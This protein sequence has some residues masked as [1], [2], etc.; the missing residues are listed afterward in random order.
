LRDLGPAVVLGLSAIVLAVMIRPPV[1]LQLT[2]L[3]LAVAAAGTALAVEARLRDRLQHWLEPVR[4]NGAPENTGA[5]LQALARG[6]VWGTGLGRGR[7]D[8]VTNAENDFILSAVT[9][10]RG[11]VGAACVVLLGAPTT[12]DGERCSPWPS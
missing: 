5:A 4:A 11:L 10:E 9:E 6:G 1:R 8:A 12:P 2:V 7:P 3:G